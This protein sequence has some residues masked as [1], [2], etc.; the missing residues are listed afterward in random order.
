[1]AEV[2]MLLFF[3]R[4]QIGSGVHQASY[5][6][7]KCGYFHKLKQPGREADQSS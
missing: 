5:P 2:Q 3:K 7:G 1:M 4:V 6:V